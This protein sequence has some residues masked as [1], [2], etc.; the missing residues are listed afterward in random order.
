MAVLVYHL[1]ILKEGCC[2][3]LTLGRSLEQQQ[4]KLPT[5]VQKLVVEVEVA[6]N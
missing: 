1:W 6:K 3:F 5:T 2:S 4:R